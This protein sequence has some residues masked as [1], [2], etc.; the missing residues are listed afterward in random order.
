MEALKKWYD[1]YGVQLEKASN[2]NAQE[3][4]LTLDYHKKSAKGYQN[5]FPYHTKTSESII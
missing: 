2:E 4:N 5:I 1:F 3:I